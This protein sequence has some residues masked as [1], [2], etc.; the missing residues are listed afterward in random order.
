M[1]NHWLFC[2]NPK[3]YSWDSLTDNAARALR[4]EPQTVRWSCQS[5]QVQPGDPAWMLRLGQAPK[6]IFARGTVVGQPYEDTHYRP[7][8]AADG[9]TTWYVDIELDEIYLPE[10]ECLLTQHE[11]EG[12]KVEAQNWSPQSSGIELKPLT[13][14]IVTKLWETKAAG[15]KPE[16]MPD[17]SHMKE[18]KNLILFG[19]PG[20]GKTWRLM[21]LMNDYSSAEP[22][23]EAQWLADKLGVLPWYSVLALALHDLG[24][25]A[26]VP[27]LEQHRY[28]SAKA[29]AQGRT[30]NL[31]QT[32]W[33]T[34]N[35]Q[36]SPQSQTVNQQS[37]R[38]PY[39]FDKS[40]DSSWHLQ[41]N[42]KKD[43]PELITLLAELG[44][45][46][47]A[48]SKTK[49][50]ELVTFHQSYGYEDF[51]E[52]IRPVSEAEGGDL[53]FRVK[54]GIFR[55]ICKRA[56]EDPDHKYA[57][58][59][60]EINRANIAKVLG[61]L[62]TL[63]EPDKRVR[64][65]SNGSLVNGIELTLPYSQDNFGVPVNLDIYGTM[66]TADRSI[67][68]IDTALRRRFQFEEL[69]P[70]ASKIEGSRGDDIIEDGEGDLIHLRELL[71]TVNKR[72]TAL[73]NREMTLG[74]AYL[75]K[76]KSFSDLD[77]VI[78]NKWMPLL[79]EYFYEDWHRIRLVFNDTNAPTGQQI[80]LRQAL[81][82]AALFPGSDEISED[83]ESFSIAD[84]I[85][86]EAVRKIYQ[87]T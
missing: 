26:R 19:P 10:P 82:A 18:P 63:I 28:I 36:T 37:R 42:W 46:P 79:Q 68:L 56:E 71:D 53:Q 58:F 57:L 44:N 4:G 81:S 43:L 45:G 15:L 55:R 65:D 7:E 2:W 54:P 25:S 27:D 72:I 13:A 50:Y 64:Y 16:K 87:T 38:E 35:T 73:L 84:R 52:G 47:A 21:Q 3:N 5:R 22:Q 59:I 67:S 76:C 69:M 60:D 51:V 33:N 39:I 70:D 75:M 9:D 49:R 77:S 83:Y 74:H 86:P 23:S 40:T 14:N 41:G 85:T 6:G 29:D 32:L 78:K 62:I 11:L 24:G 34:L 61:E 30:N 66:N 1:V 48:D 31:K 80:V 17:Q 12:I 8:R 20:T